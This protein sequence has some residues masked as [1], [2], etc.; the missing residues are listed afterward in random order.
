M[1]TTIRLSSLLFERFSNEAAKLVDILDKNNITYETQENT[2]DIWTRDYMPIC[3]DDGT[4]VSYIYT[5]DYLKSDKY[6]NS[7]TQIEYE[8]NHMDIIMDGGNFVRYKNK[9]IMTEKVFNENPSKSKDEIINIIKS[10]CKLDELIIIP[11]QAHDIFGHSDSMVR[12]IDEST[13]LINDFSNE[14]KSFNER[15]QNSLTLYNLK[16]KTIKYSGNFF[17]KERTWGAYLNFIKIDNLLIVPVYGISEDE[18]VLNQIRNIYSDCTIEAI[19]F[20]KIINEGGAMHCITS[21]KRIVDEYLVVEVTQIE[22]KFLNFKMK[23]EKP[24]IL[25]YR[26][27]NISDIEEFKSFFKS[28]LKNKNFYSIISFDKNFYEYKNEQMLKDF[29]NSSI[30]FDEVTNDIFALSLPNKEIKNG[31][32]DL[33]DKRNIVLNSLAWYLLDKK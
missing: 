23:D 19:E 31:W 32:L 33:S 6:K 16:I 13:I 14:S 18:L 3:L 12:W 22:L 17:S 28:F 10:N 8:K 27:F 4:L 29:K 30:E 15:L 20:N 11:Q 26:G 5:P 24:Y 7:R 9:A 1:K 2:K 21:E 25:E